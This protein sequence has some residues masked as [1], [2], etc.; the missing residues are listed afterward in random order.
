[1]NQCIIVCDL[2]Y[3]THTLIYSVC[4]DPFHA[5]K[6]A[7]FKYTF[8]KTLLLKFTQLVDG[9]FF[10]TNANEKSI[11]FLWR[12]LMSCFKSWWTSSIHWFLCT[13]LWNEEWYERRNK[14]RCTKSVTWRWA[15]AWN[16]SHFTVKNWQNIHNWFC[17]EGQ[18]ILIN[19]VK[20][21]N[22]TDFVPKILCMKWILNTI[23]EWKTIIMF[24]T[25]EWMWYIVTIKIWSL[26]NTQL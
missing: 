13:L 4:L 14:I 17:M 11:W 3:Q 18:V 10:R 22:Q 2:R 9:T 24:L 20:L 7:E 6:H 19:T 16:S 1:M 26:L 5:E 15:I 8:W 21:K 23:K 12:K 25:G